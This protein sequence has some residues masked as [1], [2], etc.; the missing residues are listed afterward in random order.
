[1]GID[2]VLQ[3]DFMEAPGPAS[4]LQ[5]LKV[6][7]LLNGMDEDG[8][9]T[10]H[11]HALAA[12]PLDP[13]YAGCVLAADELGVRDEICTL[14]SLLSVESIWQARHEDTNAWQEFHE[15]D[16]DHHALLHAYNG[17]V[18]GGKQSRWASER[19]LHHRALRQADDVR[20]QL[21]RQLRK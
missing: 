19:L 4:L 17:W 1:M 15:P 6:L 9:L 5:A 18:R 3:F 13:Q 8:D 16:S 14:V 11:G 2:H 20:T 10:P 7:Y 12:L 21:L